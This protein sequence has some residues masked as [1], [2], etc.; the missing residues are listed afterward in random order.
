MPEVVSD[1]LMQSELYYSNFE[2][3]LNIFSETGYINPLSVPIESQLQ[4][5]V[6]SDN[7]E[8]CVFYF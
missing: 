1:T 4:S 2:K 5:M 8:S 3:Q 6:C 7:K